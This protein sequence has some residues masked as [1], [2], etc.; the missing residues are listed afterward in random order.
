MNVN[1]SIEIFQDILRL[2]ERGKRYDKDMEQKHS[3][4]KNLKE[5]M[6][7]EKDELYKIISRQNC[8]IILLKESHPNWKAVTC[9]DCGGAGGFTWD[10]PEGGGGEPC[11]CNNGIDYVEIKEG[12]KDGN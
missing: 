9:P 6:K 7:K 8:E 3:E 11:H 2:A 1:D 12:E 5:R 4:L 10:T